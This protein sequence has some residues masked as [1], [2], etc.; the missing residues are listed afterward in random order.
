M[1]VMTARYAG[2]VCFA[3][4]SNE[5]CCELGVQ[6]FNIDRKSPKSEDGVVESRNTGDG[7]KESECSMSRVGCLEIDALFRP[8]ALLIG[9]EIKVYANNVP[10]ASQIDS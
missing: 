5:R 3:W 7:R 1:V 6:S 9:R 4:G 2:Q 8:V 10:P